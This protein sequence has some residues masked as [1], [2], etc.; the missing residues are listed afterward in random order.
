VSYHFVRPQV[1][2]GFVFRTRNIPGIGEDQYYVKRLVGRPGDT[3]EI[4]PPVLY[5]NGRPIT[6]A[7][8][9]DRNARREGLYRGYFNVSRDGSYLFKDEKLTVPP[10]VFF[11]LGD[12]SASSKDGR[13]WGFVPEKEVV[14]RPLFIYYPF[15]RRWG[16]AR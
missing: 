2:D 14:G 16:P 3:L 7:A 8:A 5:R 13:Y 6:G 12:K 10:R 4:R 11:A 9:F 1:G 15:T